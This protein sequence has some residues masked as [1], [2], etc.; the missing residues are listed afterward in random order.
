MEFNA[1]GDGAGPG[2]VEVQ[3]PDGRLVSASQFGDTAADGEEIHRRTVAR[4]TEDRE[5][6][7]TRLAALIRDVDGDHTLGAAALSEALIN[8]GV[9]F[10]ATD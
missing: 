10:R 8:R 7:I 5:E 6:D 9:G 1:F 4:L 3:L 2:H